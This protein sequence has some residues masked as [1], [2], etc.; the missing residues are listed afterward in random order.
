[1]MS[2]EF[3]E[4]FIRLTAQSE[5]FAVA[6]VVRAT[7][8]TSAKPG[9][10]AIISWDGE[11]SG[12]IGGSCAQPAVIEQALEVLKDGKPRLLT[13]SPA[14]PISKQHVEEGTV[15]YVH[16]CQSHGALDIFVEPHLPQPE[17]LIIGHEPTAK[18]LAKLGKLLDFKV[19]V[20]DPL[21]SRETFPDVDVI[22]ERL[23]PDELRITSQTY[24]VIATHQTYPGESDEHL[25]EKVITSKAAYMSL[26]ASKRRAGIALSYLR[27]RAIPA[28]QLSKVKSPAGLDIHAVTPN[29]IALSILAEI[30]KVRRGGQIESLIETEWSEAA[31]KPTPI[32]D[33]RHAESLVEIAIDPVCKMEVEKAAAK[34]SS[35]YAGLSFYFCSSACKRTFDLRPEK[36]ITP[37]ISGRP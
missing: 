24:I 27:Q 30:V 26:V 29:E 19:I 23:A 35:T 33:E 37:K 5:P 7:R 14:G 13:L 4:R 32:E 31:G 16:S 25:L 34:Y 21:A 18:V 8:P 10:K 11:L 3:L 6:T 36:Y 17:L 28:E 20:I 15:H 1:M 22:L 2:K 12:W 9:S